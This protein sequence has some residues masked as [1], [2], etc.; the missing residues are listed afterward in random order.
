MEKKENKT[1]W[2]ATTHK[3]FVKSYLE[4]EKSVELRRKVPLGVMPGDILLVCQEGT[5]GK[6]VLKMTV[7]SVARES[8]ADLWAEYFHEMQVNFLAY[9]KYTEGC[10]KVAG[11]KVKDI[12]R[13]PEGL[14]IHDFSVDS[15]PQWFRFAWPKERA[16]ELMSKGGVI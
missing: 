15:V 8:P 7:V 4:G 13:L 12:V 6:V 10:E 14:T 11:V 2:M 5:R 1:Y 16:I 3:G 9:K